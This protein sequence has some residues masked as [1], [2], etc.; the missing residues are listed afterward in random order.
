MRRTAAVAIVPLVL[1]LTAGPAIAAPGGRTDIDDLTLLATTDTH[2]TALDYDYFTGTPFGSADKPQ[3]TR[4]MDHLST[5]IAQVRAEKGADSVILLDN[6]DANQGSSLE[7]VYHA[8]RGADTVDPMAAVSNH[9][10]YD[11]GVVGNHEFNYGL[12]DLQQYRGS[13]DFPLLGANVIDRATGKPYLEPY[14]I[15][16]KTTADGHTVKVGVVG[17]VTPGVRIWDAGKVK[18]L[19]FQDMVEAARTWVP[20]AKEAGADVIVVAA[21]TGLDADGYQWNPK[22][23]TENV[24]RSIAEKVPDIDVVIGGHS[25]VTDE[26]Q[27]YFT[28]PDGREVLYT[29]PGYHARFLSE[30]HLPL[31]LENGQVVVDWTDDEKPTATALKAADYPADPQIQQVI[32]P[33]HQKTVDWVGTVV[34]TATE[35][36]PAVESAWTDTAILDFINQVQSDELTRALKGTDNENLHVISE[37]SP[38]SRTAV[39]RKG[40]VTIADMAALYVYDNTLVGVKLTGAQVKDYLEHAARYYQQQ[41]PGAEITDWSTVTN[42][43]YPGDTRGIPDYAYDVLSGVNYHI[44]ISKPVGERIQNLTFPD[45]TPVKDDDEFALAVNDYRQ[46]GG[47]GYPHVVGAPVIYNEQQAIRDLMIQWAQDK[48]VIDPAE[49]FVENWTVSTSAAEAPSVPGEE[50]GENEQTPGETPGEDAGDPA[51]PG[52]DEGDDQDDQAE[53]PVSDAGGSDQS[54][55]VDVEVSTGG[56]ADAAPGAEHGSLARTGFDLGMPVALAAALLAGGIELIRRRKTS[57]DR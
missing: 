14:T 48:T 11:A 38:F 18:D 6:G 25:H 44:D 47:S 12:A 2:G 27:T 19:E 36:M 4:G 1:A 49:F 20:K 28:A 51:A 46:S 29:Q 43:Q 35:E 10:A 54:G 24:G 42:A 9:L 32:E 40:D 39:F 13:L 52:T 22:D 55:S 53:A 33:W 56:S 26:V 17:V 41:E 3:N 30:V 37:A 8:N 21:H 50:P 45:G 23:L 7:S 5:A 57:A 15:V 34:A 31:S 16:E